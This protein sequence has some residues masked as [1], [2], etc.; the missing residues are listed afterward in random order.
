MK[1]TFEDLE[2]L[3][4]NYS[5]RASEYCHQLGI[6]G[7]VILWFLFKESGNLGFKHY[8]LLLIALF[9]FIAVILF[10]LF[11]YYSLA[12]KADKYYHEQEKI[13]VEDGIM[14]ITTLRKSYLEKNESIEN[15]SWSYFRMKFRAL[16]F[17]YFIVF[18]YVIINLITL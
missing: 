16:F 14:D 4:G 10:S 1:V 5:K 13:K 2:K 11:H 6:A 15:L 7:I 12:I 17:G 18:L 9:V 3:I 8:W